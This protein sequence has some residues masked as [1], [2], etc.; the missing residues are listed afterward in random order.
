MGFIYRGGCCHEL[1]LLLER[2]IPCTM[3]AE[4]HDLGLIWHPACGTS[5]R[6]SE[7]YASRDM[8]KERNPLTLEMFVIPR[9]EASSLR[10]K[11][12]TW[13]VS[14]E[15]TVVPCSLSG[16]LAGSACSAHRSWHWG[17][18]LSPTHFQIYLPEEHSCTS[19]PH[20]GQFVLT[21]LKLGFFVP[22][23]ESSSMAFAS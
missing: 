4:S 8:G 11:G 9:P 21:W 23:L 16:L 13:E 19:L 12:G 5:K 22:I 7:S 6:I 17:T 10:G 14:R 1:I 15:M 20:F 3:A 2:C 18:S